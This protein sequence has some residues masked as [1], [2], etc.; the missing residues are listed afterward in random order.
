MDGYALRAADVARP[1]A[2][3]RR[4]RGRA[5]PGD[6]PLGPGRR[7]R[8]SSPAAPLPPGADA[9]ER[10]EVVDGR[11]RRDGRRS[12]TRSEPARNV[13]F[14]G[15]DVPA[16]HGAAA[17]RASGSPPQALTARRRRR[18]RRAC[19]STARPR[20]AV[21][22]TGDELVA[23]GHAARAR[24]RSTRRNGVDAAHAGR[25]RGRRGRSTSAPRP[26]T[27]PRSRRA[28]AAASTE[29]DVLLVAG[30]VSVG[31]HD[32][33]KGAL[34]RAGVEELFWRVRIKPGKP[35]FCGRTGDGALGVRPARQPAV[36]RRLLPRL[37]RAAAAPHAGR[38][39]TPPSAA[40]AVRTTQEIAPGGRPHD[41]PHRDARG[42]AT[43]ASPRRR[44][45]SSRARR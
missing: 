8:A 39:R 28:S 1:P 29:A 6:A 45:P 34:D 3:R 14:R 31:E 15:E 30:G 35:L 4:G 23:A 20:V 32:H 5:T 12:T 24:A 11:R 44:R 40:S 10:Q 17:R 22:A 2:R 16:G 25:P 21:L 26:T 38:G 19:P 27:R 42:A 7:A 36:G 18:P 43:T 9:V 37:R 33:V 13:R 41:L